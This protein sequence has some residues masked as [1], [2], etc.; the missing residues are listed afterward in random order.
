MK[1][2][3][4]AQPNPF[5]RAFVRGG[6]REGGEEYGQY[7]DRDAQWGAQPEQNSPRTKGMRGSG[8]AE[9]FG[10]FIKNPG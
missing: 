10:D 6:F 1:A 8:L 9:G 4:R 5:T 3:G 2:E 7:F